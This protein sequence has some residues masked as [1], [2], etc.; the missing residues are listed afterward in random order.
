MLCI[1]L[2]WG[3]EFLCTVRWPVQARGEVSGALVPSRSV[4]RGTSGALASLGQTLQRQSGKR[5]PD[6]LASLPL[7]SKKHHQSTM[8]A[9]GSIPADEAAA[10]EA[11]KTDDD[12]AIYKFCTGL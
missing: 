2:L 7:A 1:R 11:G 8:G 10:K 4:R 5:A 12:I 6:E 3:V 9:G